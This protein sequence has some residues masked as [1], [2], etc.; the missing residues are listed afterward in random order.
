MTTCRAGKD[1]TSMAVTLEE[2]VLLRNEHKMSDTNFVK[3]L[4]TLRRYE[5]AI[6]YKFI[7]SL[8]AVL[9]HS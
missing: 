3:V 5:S 8:F 1:R 2:C 7:T 4:S 9:A 6:C